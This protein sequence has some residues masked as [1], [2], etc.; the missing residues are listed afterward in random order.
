MQNKYISPLLIRVDLAPVYFQVLPSF[1]SQW[2]V[3]CFFKWKDLLLKP[4][5]LLCH[6]LISPIH[7]GLSQIRWI[8]FLPLFEP[9]Q[10]TAVR[11][12]TFSSCH[13]YT[14]L[15]WFALLCITL[16]LIWCLAG[17]VPCALGNA[18]LDSLCR[19]LPCACTSILCTVCCVPCALGNALQDPHCRYLPNL[20]F[21]VWVGQALDWRVE[22]KIFDQFNNLLWGLK[23]DL[24][25]SSREEARRCCFDV[26]S[27]YFSTTVSR[28]SLL[29]N[30]V[31][32][33]CSI[34]LLFNYCVVSL[35]SA[36]SHYF[37]STV[38][39]CL[40]NNFSTTVSAQ[41]KTNYFGS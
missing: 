5:A 10:S 14:L 38:R 8:L 32:W 17:L 36:L 3:F 39:V 26:S 22:I 28:V 20:A 25:W 24:Y 35:V 21:Y 31:S 33:V 37:S 1:P 23:D 6:L 30:T 15:H 19:Y 29:F 2:E 34:S 13:F 7:W 27:H 41:T 4:Q 9:L 40:L 18:L 16:L 11:S 12:Q